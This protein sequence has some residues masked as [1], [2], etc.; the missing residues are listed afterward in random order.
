MSSYLTISETSA[1]I[2]VSTDDWEIEFDE[3]K[4]GVID[5]WC[6]GG[7]STN[8]ASSAD[9]LWTVGGNKSSNDP[10]LHGA[11]SS[12][13]AVLEQSPLRCIVMFTG[14][15]GNYSGQDYE[16]YYTIYPSGYIHIDFTW[17][18]NTGGGISYYDYNWHRLKTDTTNYTNDSPVLDDSDAS[19]T[20]NS[21]FWY[22]MSS[23]DAIDSVFFY[24]Q[25]ID[26]ADAQ[27][28]YGATDANIA[29]YQ[30]DNTH[31]ITD[32][33]SYRMIGALYIGGSE[34]S[35][36]AIEADGDFLRYKYIP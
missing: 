31:T 22:G 32:G 12:T 14:E 28:N 21:Q 3:A 25:Y 20:Y 15:V 26:D 29:R 23:S 27:Q 9:G 2:N 6:Q 34:S 35:E 4:G 10:W 13:M 7:G 5:K 18:N 11:T 19:P 24:V 17:T 30:R 8:Y 16:L 1:T 33:Q 36:A